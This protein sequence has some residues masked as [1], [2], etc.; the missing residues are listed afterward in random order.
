MKSELVVSLVVA[1][2]AHGGCTLMNAARSVCMTQ[3]WPHCGTRQ[4]NFEFS[5]LENSQGRYS[6]S[7]HHMAL[8]MWRVT[9]WVW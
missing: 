3:R 2:K 5:F 8:A 7:L 1:N 6:F 4:A 9:F